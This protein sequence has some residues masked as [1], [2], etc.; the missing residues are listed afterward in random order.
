MVYHHD[1]VV[2]IIR[3]AEY[4]S[5]RRVYLDKA[6]IS[7]AVG[8]IFFR[9]DDIQGSRLGDIQNYVLMTYTPKAW[10]GRDG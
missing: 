4:I 9:N 3:L 2:D 10:F 6:S 7:S 5:T 8:C 1:E